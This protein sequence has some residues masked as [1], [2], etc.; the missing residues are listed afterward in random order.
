MPKAGTLDDMMQEGIDSS[1]ALQ[2]RL[3]CI[4]RIA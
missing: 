4:F 3:L 2:A 1:S